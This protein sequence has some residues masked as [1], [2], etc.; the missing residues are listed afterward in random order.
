MSQ[1]KPPPTPGTIRKT[2]CHPGANEAT[3]AFTLVE[4][5]VSLFCIILLLTAAMPLLTDSL[6]R[7]QTNTTLHKLVADLQYVQQLAIKTEDT[8]ACYEVFFY[9]TQQQYVI[10]HGA[11]LL[12][13]EKFPF[14]VCLV[15]TNFGQSGETQILTFN[16]Q[17]NPVQAGTITVMNR[18]SGKIYLVRVAV[19]SGRVRIEAL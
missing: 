19:L 10:R 8:T 3:R 14:Y 2:V 1:A 18:R 17:G 16:I 11:K 4:M 5:L 9:P 15:S 13:T 7:Y 12:R 6:A